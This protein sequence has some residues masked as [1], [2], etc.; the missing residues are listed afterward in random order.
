MI[1]FILAGTGIGYLCAGVALALTGSWWL[2]L[3]VLSGAG[4]AATIGLALRRALC[5]RT[6]RTGALAGDPAP[7]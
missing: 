4:S 7:Q 3:A 1:G 6:S 5:S 2:A